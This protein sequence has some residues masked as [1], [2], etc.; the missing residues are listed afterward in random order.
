[1]NGL[2]HFASATKR[3]PAIERWELEH[4]G[5]LG[6]IAMRWFNVMRSCGPDVRE[7]LHDGYPTACVGDAAF[8]YVGAFK[9]HVN[10]GF[11]RG[12]EIEDPES[13]LEGSGKYMRHVK[14]RP[15]AEIDEDA[16]TRLIEMAYE[17]MA[18]RL[19]SQ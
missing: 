14:L 1:M 11:F 12:A 2:F 4:R 13:L 18:R 6:G 7:I 10:V 16:L 19:E 8:A 9:T 3:D 5:E 17:D 15:A